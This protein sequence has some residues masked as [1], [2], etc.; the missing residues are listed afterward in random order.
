MPCASGSIRS[1]RYFNSIA[2]VSPSAS[3][4]AQQR[5]T[6]PTRWIRTKGNPVATTL[7]LIDGSTVTNL[8]GTPE[9]VANRLQVKSSGYVDLTT[10]DG[11]GKIYVNPKAVAAIVEHQVGTAHFAHGI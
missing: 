8:D 2:L 4:S 11:N 6:D 7:H 1:T 10:V 9:D 5:D 3:R